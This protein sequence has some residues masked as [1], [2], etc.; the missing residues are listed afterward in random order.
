MAARLVTFIVVSIVA[1]TFAAGIITRAQRD[2]QGPVDLV[3]LNGRIYGGPGDPVAEAVAVRGGHIVAVGTNRE[4]KRLSR[5]QTL[6]IDA[7]GASVLPGLI[8]TQADFLAGARLPA[9]VAGRRAAGPPLD[10][11]SASDLLRAGIHAAHQRGVTSVQTTGT[12]GELALWQSLRASRELA[13]RVY[14]T[15]PVTSSATDADLAALDAS[16]AQFGDDP[17]LKTGA[18]ELSAAEPD[19]DTLVTRLD[20]RG[21][22]LR[23]F[24]ATPG[25]AERAVTAFEHAA[26][27]NSSD[28]E[29]RHRLLYAGP[30][31]ADL[32]QRLARAGAAHL[33]HPVLGPNGLPSVE[34]PADRAA[35][36]DALTATAALASF[37]EQR[38]GRLARG[39]VA[40]L[41]I[42]SGD[43]FAAPVEQLAGVAVAATIFEG[44]VVFVRDG[45]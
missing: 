7:H 26:A 18:L 12:T 35:A 21:W 31:D 10:D 23:V 27:A 15:A 33:P 36:V 40:D 14:H 9:D 45:E 29:R 1:G 4:M 8:E 44:R 30:L 28:G 11:D 5:K 38:K 25:E 37:D 17:L 34:A 41:V 20:A 19:V 32:T 6:V 42:L 22:Q 13:L 24:A 16:R 39:Q 43:L 3:V 2:E